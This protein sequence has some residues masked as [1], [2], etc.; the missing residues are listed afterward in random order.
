MG[1]DRNEGGS[2]GAR[3]PDSLDADA[4]DLVAQALDRDADDVNRALQIVRQFLSERELVVYGGLGLDYALRLKGDQIYPDDERPDYDMLSPRNVDDAYD[5]AERLHAAGLPRVE[6][7]R[8]LHVQTMRVWVNF[9]SV[10]DI[11]FVPA[12]AYALIPTLRYGP[13]GEPPVRVVHPHWQFMDQ[14]QAFCFPF[15]D[16]PR[17][18]VFHRFGKDLRRYNRLYSHYPLDGE[19]GADEGAGGATGGAAKA[20]AEGAEGADRAGARLPVLPGRTA[21]HGEAARCLLARMG[22]VAAGAAPAPLAGCDA[23]AGVVS[24]PAPA[25]WDGGAYALA[26]CEADGGA[27]VLRLLGYEPAGRYR[28]FLDVMPPVV[29]GRRAAG[30]DPAHPP[31][32]LLFN[33][34]ARLLAAVTLEV[35]VGGA[36]RPLRVASPQY[37]LM[38]YLFGYHVLQRGGGGG[39]VF[40]RYPPR[41]D[42]AAC[43][44]AYCE[45]RRQVAAGYA[46]VMARAAGLPDGQK[47][48]LLDA[49]PFGLT[50]QVLGD[51]NYGES[52]LIIAARDAMSARRPPADPVLRALVPGGSEVGRLPRRYAPAAGKPRP[53]F[54]YGALEWFRWDGGEVGGEEAAETRQ[55]A[56]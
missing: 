19:D 9:V 32:L 2:G 26:A 22:E 5:L 44:R 34:P 6:A 16:P 8:A 15:R 28:P 49:T 52:Q 10:A 39:T 54:D 20:A 31:V 37:L 35:A 45:V 27:E 36:R 23:G 17:E 43:R 33:H 56:T 50:T 12:A 48:A 41:P 7:K 47:A 51:K 29:V 24:V 21:L 46:A 53:T 55:A 4:L 40:D 42:A 11:S 3:V 14:H 18:P 25:G 1:I 38:H 13:P 30:S